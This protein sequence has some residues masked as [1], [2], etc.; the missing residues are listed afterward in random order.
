MLSLL[1]IWSVQA[2]DHYNFD[3]DWK[4]YQGSI[5]GGSAVGTDVSNWE[6]VT[7]PHTWNALDG[8]DGGDD[9][10]RGI[11][12]YRKTF[13]LPEEYAG[14]IV[15]LRIGSANMTT[16]VYVNG[17]RVGSH[18]G[19]YAAFMFD[20]TDKLNAD[21]E[22]LI[23][24]QVS[25]A[26]T[27]VYAPL[28]GDFT[29]YGG[30]TRSV[31]LVVCDSIHINPIKVI[32]TSYTQ[33]SIS[34]ATPGV[35]IR[36]NDVSESSAI[37][38]VET[39]LRNAKAE[40]TETTV[41]A[42]ICDAD[43]NAVATMSETK[44]IAAADTASSKLETT[45]MSPHLWNG[46][47][48]PYLYRV[49]V[50]LKVNDEV[51]DQVVQ[52]L[53]LRYFEVRP[54]EGFFLN[55]ELYPLRG[56][57]FH[58]DAEDKGRA[59]SDDDRKRDVDILAETG[60]NYFRLAHYQHGDYTYH[61]LDTLGIICWTEVPVVDRVGVGTSLSTFQYNANQQLYELM[62]QQ[63]NHPCV[64][65]WGIGN[66]ITNNATSGEDPDAVMTTLNNLAKTLNDTYRVTTLAAN[67]DLA[68]NR[69]PD[70]Y[71]M[72]RYQGWYS[73]TVANF[74]SGMDNLHNSYPNNAV[75]VS[76]YGAGANTTQH[77][78]PITT[79]PTTTGHYHPEEYQNYFHEAYLEAINARDWLWGTAI[80]AGFDFSSDSRNEG[81]MPGINDKGLVTRDRKTKKDAYFLYKA[82]W[83]KDEPMVYITSR[84][85]DNR[86]SLQ[87]PVKVYSNCES[88]TLNVNGNEIGS[89]TSTNVIFMWEDVAVLEGE[90]TI[91]VTGTAADGTTT[92]SDTVVWNCT[93]NSTI[94]PTEPPAGD[95]QVNFGLETT[96]APEGYWK[97]YGAV[98]ADHGE[99]YSY[100]WNRNNTDN[101]RE[102]GSVDDVR[103]DS[104]IQ[105]GSGSTYKWSI[106]V[107][108]GDYI[109]SVACGDPDYTDSYHRVDVN[110]VLF[111][112][113]Y[114]GSTKFDVTTDTVSVT[115]GTLTVSVASNGDN[116]KINYIHLT[117]IIPVSIENA[118]A[119]TF[120][121]VLKGNT[122]R[123]NFTSAK[124]R[125]FH[126]YDMAGR[127]VQRG[128][129]RQA[130]MLIPLSS[131]ASGN[132]AACI[133]DGAE[134]VRIKFCK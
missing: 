72:N 78:Y 50:S 118:T 46:L 83:N 99:T 121:W 88:V 1:P 38:T 36:Q 85:Y 14:K 2:A 117:Q 56:F 94:Y 22:N 68:S 39:D 48:D 75:G 66:E 60:A 93:A 57:A 31:E 124:E 77:E 90:N 132:Y 61:Y 16:Q 87:I 73:G 35:L 127:L 86:T 71:A 79:A 26:S 131:L 109:V 58:E 18:S 130:E 81:A 133:Q 114:P 7:L 51:T 23:A 45:I 107:P 11:G 19:G 52:P 129:S 70:V 6:D 125:T 119:S 21:E 37:V 17:E 25:N 30:I 28:S 54:A 13:E 112:N 91:I 55:G 64:A 134:T 89:T 29:F 69:I 41:E 103:Y 115:D 32:N 84:R 92:V 95:I 33:T 12:W 47:N 24:I 100:G 105:M 82:S 101:G 74:G 116:V 4:F 3:Q 27:L 120:S 67:Y 96:E 76:E 20:I 97:D 102:R 59:I 65:F 123:A 44:T 98:F 40:E 122:L 110:G 53:G 42:V 5:S 128:S 15:Y 9:Y 43:G 104:F 108:D 106:E 63:F 113:F 80:W 49:E 34:V 8:Q 111:N 10:Y 126:I 62:Y